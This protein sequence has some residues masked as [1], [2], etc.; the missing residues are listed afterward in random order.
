MMPAIEPRAA[1]VAG[2]LAERSITHASCDEDAV[3]AMQAVLDA[4]G[5]LEEVLTRPGHLQMLHSG[6]T[7]QHSIACELSW[8]TCAVLHKLCSGY[9]LITKQELCGDDQILAEQLA[10]ETAAAD[11]AA[12]TSRT[13]NGSAVAVYNDMLGI[14]QL[15]GC[16]K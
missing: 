7:P 8:K 5:Q 12:D 1:E 16:V 9:A 14:A 15:L 10:D 6:R 13:R 4:G 2:T 3:D 11:S